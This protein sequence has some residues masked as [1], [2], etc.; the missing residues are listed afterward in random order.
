MAVDFGDTI[1]NSTVQPDVAVQNPVEDNSGAILASSL[2][3]AFNAIGAIAG[4]IFKESQDKDNNSVLVN[5]ENDLLDLADAVEQGSMKTNEA[6]V[7]ARQI[8]RQYLGNAPA[9]QADF[10]KVWTNFV[11]AN[12]LGNVVRTGTME[13]QAE[14]A[15]VQ[16]A[17]K[18]GYPDVQTY[19]E[20]QTAGL[21]VTALNQQLE[22]IKAR[23]G[24]ITETQRNEALGAVVGLAN[25]AFPAAQK[26]ILEAQRAIEANPENKAAIVEQ[27]N[28]TIGSSIAQ[29]DAMGQNADTAYI[30]DPIK[31]LMS[32]FND[33]ANNTVENTVL[34]N[35]LKYTQLQYESMFANDPT[36]GPFIAQSKLLNSV[37]LADSQLG[38]N[39]LTPDVVKALKDATDPTKSLNILAN[40]D[41]NERFTQ[42]VIKM[43]ET[44][45]DNPEAVEEFK[46]VIGAVVDGAYENERTNKDGAMGYKGTIEVLGSPAVKEALGTDPIPA[47]YADQFVQVIQDNYERELV[48]VI[49]SYWE[50][51]PVIDLVNSSMS[52]VPMNQLLDPVWNGSA[53]EFVVK[54]EWANNASVQ[55]LAADVNSGGNSIGTPLNNLINAYA[56]VTGVDAKTIYEQDFA[57]VL[58]GGVNEEGDVTQPQNTALDPVA[59]DSILNATPSTLTLSDFNA[60]PEVAF[61]EIRKVV[62]NTSAVD[63]SGVVGATNPTDFAQAFIGLNESDSTSRNIISAFI[64]QTAGIDINPAQTAWCAAFVDAVLHSTGGQGTGKLNARSYLDWGVPV[65]EPKVGD[66]VVFSRGDPNGWQG[67][68]GFY[69]GKNADGTIKVLGGNQGDE[70]SIDNFSTDRLL[71]YRRASNA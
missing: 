64:K 19:R 40:N 30:T 23:G 9:L 7:R 10:D 34:E 16:E 63:P 36:L 59:P 4:T 41:A 37:G 68:V 55:S 28:M 20:F 12:G 1:I 65:T 51:V 57:P 71:G 24:I 38:Q 61:E 42:S 44:G 17:F 31:S 66:V 39:L 26:Q 8:R 15:L 62:D 25:S 27:L 53:V 3:G 56:N 46:T 14:Q 18:L 69:A 45:V 22:A 43:A 52:N 33:W 5:Y 70:V 32:T 50:S 2:G 13:Q 54:P 47:E 6:M 21:K 35:N 58:F 67:H 48:P 29:L 49:Q 60:E 11:D